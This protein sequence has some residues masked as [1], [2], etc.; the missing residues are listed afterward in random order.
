M[1]GDLLLAESNVMCGLGQGHILSCVF[2]K[3]TEAMWRLII[4]MAADSDIAC[5]ELRFKQLK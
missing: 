1:H 4:H 3:V 2:D 5:L